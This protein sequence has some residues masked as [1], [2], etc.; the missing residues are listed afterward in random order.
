MAAGLRAAPTTVRLERHAAWL[1]SRAR[2]ALTGQGIG[3]RAATELDAWRGVL[4]AE[5]ARTA[6]TLDEATVLASIV[7]GSMLNE[8]IG[9]ILAY[10]VL[11]ALA[12]GEDRVN[13]TGVPR[14][15]GVDVGLPLLDESAL[16]AKVHR[17]GPA[18]DAALRDALSRWWDEDQPSTVEGFG[19]V[20]IV[21][22]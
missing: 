15:Y 10:E 16:L 1:E 20:G 17:L 21:V 18:A 14:S 12:P 13:G 3:S 19:A 2:R 4:A 11:D 9:S 7:A 8:G 5:L 22:R 6:W